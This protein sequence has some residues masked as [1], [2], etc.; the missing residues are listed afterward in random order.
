VVDIYNDKSP[1]SVNSG[2]GF[3][4]VEKVIIWYN[5]SSVNKLKVADS[6]DKKYALIFTEREIHDLKT[7]LTI[8]SARCLPPDRDLTEEQKNILES[9]KSIASKIDRA[10][11]ENAI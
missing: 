10:D 8:F 1:Q 2:W 6:L 5:N 4:L 3:F 9:T 7:I 11:P